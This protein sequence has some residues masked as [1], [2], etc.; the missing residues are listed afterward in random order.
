[1][2]KS[3]PIRIIPP[4]LKSDEYAVGYARKDIK[5]GEVFVFKVG[6]SSSD[7][8]MLSPEYIR[9]VLRDGQITHK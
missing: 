1:M 3:K 9:I 2:H 7:Q 4:K 8:I 6:Q 5:A